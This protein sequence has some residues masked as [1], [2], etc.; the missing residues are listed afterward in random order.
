MT[1]TEDVI[2]HWE[3]AWASALEVW[4]RYTRLRPPVFCRS[5]AEAQREG[6]TGSFAMI[7]LTDQAI[8]VSIPEVVRCGVLPYAREILAHEIGHHVYAPA[9]LTDHGRTLARIRWALPTLEAQAPL[10]ANL[11]TDLLIND[12]LQRSA[13]LRMADVYRQLGRDT[14]PAGKVWALYMRIYELLWRLE[15]GSLGGGT[16]EDAMEGDAWLGSRLVRSF[17]RDWIDGAGRFAAL[18]LPYLLEDRASQSRL[19]KWLDTRHA[20]VGGMPDGLICEEKGE[21]S[22]ALHPS[23][24]PAITGDEAMGSGE[25]APA[26]HECTDGVAHTPSPGQCREPFQYGE[27]LRALG[28]SLTDHEAAIRY[29]RERALPHLV[30]FPTRRT[31]D[32]LD[33]LPEGLEPWEIG[34]ALDEIDWMQTVLQSPRVIPGLTT[35]QRVWGSSPGAEPRLRPVDLDLY[36]DSSGSMPNPQRLTSYLT[37]AGA[38][39][40]LSALRAGA[41]VQAT[42]WSGARQFTCTDGFTR[43]ERAVLGVLTGFFGGGTAFPIHVLRDTFAQ[44]PASANPVHILVISDDGVTTLFENDERGTSGWTIAADALA[45]ARGGGSLVLNLDPQWRE[46]TAQSKVY[47]D[48]ARA[49][50]QGWSISAVRSWGE[51]E[52]FARDFSRRT[53]A[54]NNTP[55]EGEPRV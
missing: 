10:V 44:R 8:V 27:L 34:H 35:V 53:Y 50:E 25:S 3:D 32:R 55:R 30:P 23:Q 38:I 1:E 18:L 17:A 33:P 46:H 15:R 21:R 31:P 43:D 9:T 40:A 26:P 41:R 29:Y 5:A 52:Q 20:G 49:Q 48:L 14:K 7:R 12:R 16:P 2:H 39:I 28:I 37:L 11:Y 13:E 47:A 4:S 54:T 45:S 51:L 36:V 22:S 42:L 19:D 24:D 6:L